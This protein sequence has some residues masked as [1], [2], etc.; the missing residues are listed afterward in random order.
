MTQKAMGFFMGDEIG[1]LSIS[2]YKALILLRST[3][4]SSQLTEQP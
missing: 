3:S 1:Q 2:R 4:D